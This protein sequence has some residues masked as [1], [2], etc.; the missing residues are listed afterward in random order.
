MR[1]S[2]GSFMRSPSAPLVSAAAWLLALLCLGQ[3]GWARGSPLPGAGRRLP[4][5][6]LAS[7]ALVAA[8]NESLAQ[9]QVGPRGTREP[10]CACPAAGEGRAR[11]G[12]ER[13]PAQS[14][15]PKRSEGGR[16]S[17]VRGCSGP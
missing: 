2:A 6:L 13:L 4:A 1:T 10:C 15:S 11:P 7:A 3:A 9:L 16:R 14:P 8:A 17:L 12:P 5:C